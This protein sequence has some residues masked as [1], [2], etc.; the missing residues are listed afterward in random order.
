MLLGGLRRVT[1]IFRHEVHEALRRGF[2]VWADCPCA[3]IATCTFCPF[4]KVKFSFSKEI[5]LRY[6]ILS[7]ALPQ[8]RMGDMIPISFSKFR[9]S[10]FRSAQEVDNVYSA[11]NMLERFEML[12][13]RRLSC[14][15][16]SCYLNLLLTG[17]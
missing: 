13:K 15:G 6:L 5:V 12:V 7:S 1:D 4:V 14:F 11:I 8:R 10:R 2:E 17:K 3:F 9:L 16:R